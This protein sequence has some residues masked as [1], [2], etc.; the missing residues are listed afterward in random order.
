MLMSLKTVFSRADSAFVE[1]MVGCIALFVLLFAGLML[2][3]F[4]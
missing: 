2:P 1:D 4:I 3:G